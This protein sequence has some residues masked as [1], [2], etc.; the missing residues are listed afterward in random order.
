MPKP[1]F[2]PPSFYKQTHPD[3]ETYLNSINYNKTL[4]VAMA[5]FSYVR[6]EKHRG[7]V[8]DNIKKLLEHKED[9]I[10]TLGLS[11]DQFNDFSNKLIQRA[12][13]HDL[14]KYLE[15]EKIAYI[16]LNWKFDQE[17]IH[18]MEYNYPD[19]IQEIVNQAI[20]HHYQHNSHHSEFHCYKEDGTQED[21]KEKIKELLKNMSNLDLLEMVADW[22]AVSQEYGTKCTDFAKATIGDD[23]AKPFSEEQKTKIFKLINLFEPEYQAKFEKPLQQDENTTVSFRK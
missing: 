19:R 10:K 7:L 2:S 3:Q 6:M 16:Y 21:N 22:M 12:E 20:Q 18:K 14:S 13:Q 8:L 15:P 11:E 17:K 1:V 23:K 4:S 5:E 9:L